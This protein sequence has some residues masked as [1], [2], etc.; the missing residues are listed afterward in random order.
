[1][2]TFLSIRYLA[3]VI[4]ALAGVRRPAYEAGFGSRSKDGRMDKTG[5][6]TVCHHSIIS[7]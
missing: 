4:V 6:R 3:P 2:V 7:R 5:E 1:M